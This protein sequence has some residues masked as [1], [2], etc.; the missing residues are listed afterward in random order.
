MTRTEAIS[1]I[2]AKL[3]T[4]PDD[5]LEVLAEVAQAADR[6]TIYSTLSDAEKAEIDV[7]LDALDRGEGIPGEQVFDRLRQRIASAKSGA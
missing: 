7:A 3:D 1:L 5:R 2:K 4:L 6:P